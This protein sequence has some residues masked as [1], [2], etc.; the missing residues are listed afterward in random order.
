MGFGWHDDSQQVRRNVSGHS[1]LKFEVYLD[2]YATL[3]FGLAYSWGA[4][5]IYHTNYFPSPSYTHYIP[6][7]TITL[8]KPDFELLPAKYESQ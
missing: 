2:F 1:I 3:D 7:L 5:F 6:S 4:T 8:A